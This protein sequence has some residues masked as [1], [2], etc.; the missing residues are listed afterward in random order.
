MLNYPDFNKLLNL[1]TDASSR[2]LGAVLLARQGNEVI[3][4]E[5]KEDLI[6]KL[7]A[8]ILTPMKENETWFKLLKE[9]TISNPIVITTS[10]ETFIKMDRNTPS[11]NQY[12]VW[13]ID[14]KDKQKM[15]VEFMN[16]TELEFQQEVRDIS[17]INIPI[18]EIKIVETL[19]Q[20]ATQNPTLEERENLIKQAHEI[21][22]FGE[23]SMVKQIRSKGFNWSSIRSDCYL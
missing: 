5:L 22:H 16:H 17:Q 19:Q 3:W 6:H 15:N 1:A 21:G 18:K 10:Q 12:V 9:Y 8:S 2:G 11:Y 4:A 23:K 20:E 14:T 7:L 13:T